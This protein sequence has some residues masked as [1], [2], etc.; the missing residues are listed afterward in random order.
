MLLLGF[1]GIRR[2]VRQKQWRQIAI[3]LLTLGSLTV[4]YAILQNVNWYSGLGWGPRYLL[5]AIPFLM[6][7]ILPVIDALPSAPGWARAV[8]VGIIAQSVLI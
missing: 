6:L 3:P 4:G 8:A 7:W 1:W 5:P 2:L